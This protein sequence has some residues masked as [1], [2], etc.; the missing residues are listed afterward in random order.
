MRQKGFSAIIVIL[1][2]IIIGLLA[3]LVYQS[4]NSQAPATPTPTP[5][6]SASP[7]PVATLGPTSTPTPS[8]SGNPGWNVYQSQQYG[9]QISYPNSYQALDGQNDLYGWP[10]GV[11]LF[12]NGGQAY[13]IVI[14][15]WDSMAQYDQHH[16]ASETF[17]S[18]VHQIGN[19]YISVTDYTAEAENASV[20]A[21][22]QEL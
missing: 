18:E 7:S 22:F 13:D 4:F 8:P 10:Y 11:V 14:E 17:N 6:V 2:V 21:T 1:L 3:F 16:P 20:I 5:M 12:Y 9:F 19:K 15:V